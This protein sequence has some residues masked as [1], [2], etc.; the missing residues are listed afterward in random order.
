MTGEFLFSL[1]KNDPKT[2]TE[3]LYKATKYMN[4][5]DA[6]IAR[7]E[8]LRKR[9]RQDDVHPDKSRKVARTNE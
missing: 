3:M 6:I 1:Y 5:E 9:Q 4:A 2:T 8:V 7:G